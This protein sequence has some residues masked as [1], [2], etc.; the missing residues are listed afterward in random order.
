MGT[1][2]W[3]GQGPF[4]TAVAPGGWVMPRGH[5][6]SVPPPPPPCPH[7]RGSHPGVVTPTGDV[8]PVSSG[9]HKAGAGPQDGG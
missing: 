4:R 2:R 1:L 6:P 3:R 7:A 9:A 5:V 8:G